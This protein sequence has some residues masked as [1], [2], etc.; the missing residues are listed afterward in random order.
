MYTKKLV[1]ILMKSFPNVPFIH[2]CWKTVNKLEIHDINIVKSKLSCILKSSML[3]SPKVRSSLLLSYIK[4]VIKKISCLLER[5]YIH[6]VLFCL[7]FC[8]I[9]KNVCFNCSTTT[10]KITENKSGVLHLTLEILRF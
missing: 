5:S 9:Q 3:L 4:H 1:P 2:V 8:C 10:I 7:F 6:Q